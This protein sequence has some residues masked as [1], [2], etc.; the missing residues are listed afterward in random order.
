MKTCT[1]EGC[2]RRH[3]ARGLCATHYNAWWFHQDEVAEPPLQGHDR[4]PTPHDQCRFT[5]NRDDI[6][7]WREDIRQR[8][9]R[10]DAVRS[11]LWH[12]AHSDDVQIA[13]AD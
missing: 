13:S 10:W 8:F 3:Q 6:E 1:V 12:R 5:I 4:G 7:R 11:E 2:N 9:A